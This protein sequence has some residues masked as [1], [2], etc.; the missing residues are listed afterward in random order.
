MA[1]QTL[2]HG[3]YSVML[4]SGWS[5]GSF[6]VAHG[7]MDRGFRTN[8]AITPQTIPETVTLESYVADMKDSMA[9]TLEQY[10][11][12]KEGPARFGSLSGHLRE[13]SFLAEGVKIGQYQL[14]VLTKGLARVFT[15][16]VR[17]E[18]LS[19]SRPTAE[20][21]FSGIQIQA[22]ELKGGGTFKLPI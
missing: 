2:R 16:S 11:V 20:A 3:E 17:A 18:K 19:A 15:Y 9:R 1:P 12:H 22:A 10:V 14:C 6:I 4:P 8:L 13:H 7:P 21:L 5:D